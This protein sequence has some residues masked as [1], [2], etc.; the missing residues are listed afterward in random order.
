MPGYLVTSESILQCPHGGLAQPSAPPDA[1]VQVAGAPLIT[2]AVT[3][4]ITGCSNTPPCSVGTW[5][6]PGSQV[7]ANGQPV[8]FATTPLTC[9]P[10]PPAPAVRSTQ[11]AVKG[12]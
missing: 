4:A 10:Q 12:R 2:A 3:Y 6:P 1:K 9:S 7:L 5:T 11:V 8:V